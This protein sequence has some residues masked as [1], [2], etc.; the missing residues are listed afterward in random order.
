MGWHVHHQDGKY[1]IWSTIVDNYFWEEWVDE[2]TIIFVF[3]EQAR[4]DARKRAVEALTS[5]RE[6]GFCS[7]RIK[8]YRCTPEL[9]EEM[10]R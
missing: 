2:D 8:P 3:Q 4:K 5:A 6:N 1:N 9:V 10:Q 7:V